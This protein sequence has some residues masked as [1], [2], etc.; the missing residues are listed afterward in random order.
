MKSVVEPEPII[1]DTPA[2]II[3]QARCGLC[4]G[5][6]VKVTRVA[7]TH[8]G[9]WNNSWTP[10]MD[11]TVGYTRTISKITQWGVRFVEAGGY[12]Y[13]YFVL[14]IVKKSVECKLDD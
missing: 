10:D 12:S 8:E 5:D 13:P 11:S 1:E 2:Y 9:G 6:T 7:K 14:E 4:V 3:K